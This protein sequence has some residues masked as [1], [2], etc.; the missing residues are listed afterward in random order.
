[1]AVD[2]P[3]GAGG[4]GLQLAGKL[5]LEVGWYVEGGIK[6]VWAEFPI[7]LTST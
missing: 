1:M 5:A 2:R 6:H 3:P 7:P 4:L